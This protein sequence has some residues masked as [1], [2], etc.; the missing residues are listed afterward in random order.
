MKRFKNLYAATQKNWDFIT[1]V[2]SLKPENAMGEGSGIAH[3]RFTG[4]PGS[5]PRTP[6]AIKACREKFSHIPEIAQAS[7]KVLGDYI[8][9]ICLDWGGCEKIRTKGQRKK[10]VKKESTTPSPK[11]NP[12]EENDIK[13][14]ALSKSGRKRTVVM[15]LHKETPGARL[16]QSLGDDAQGS[17]HFLIGQLYLRKEGTTHHLGGKRPTLIEVT[18]EVIE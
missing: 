18:V 14:S 16:Y 10:S 1:Y 6:Q 11:S 8:A 4:L 17:P 9:Q 12:P 7:E 2:V 15:R 5:D 13:L 3:R